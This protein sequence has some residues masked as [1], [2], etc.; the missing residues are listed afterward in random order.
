[1]FDLLIHDSLKEYFNGAYWDY[2]DENIYF[3]QKAMKVDEE[4]NNNYF[5]DAEWYQ[6]DQHFGSSLYIF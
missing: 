4:K 6:L 2:D 3:S 5:S 1:L